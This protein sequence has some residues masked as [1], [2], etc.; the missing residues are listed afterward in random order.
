M[1]PHDLKMFTPLFPVDNL[2]H[3]D[4]YYYI[5]LCFTCCI[6]LISCPI[7]T[8]MLRIERT[9]PNGNKKQRNHPRLM[10]RGND[11]RRVK[12]IGSVMNSKFM[13]LN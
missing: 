8:T 3:M 2:M 4:D 13:I 1:T 9:K 12:T 7:M 11:G 6:V 5:Q 10:M